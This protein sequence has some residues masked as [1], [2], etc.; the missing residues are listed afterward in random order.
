VEL[1]KLRRPL[2]HPSRRRARPKTEAPHEA[3]P[4]RLARLGTRP[5]R[6][7]TGIETG[8][9]RARGHE[10]STRSSA[11]TSMSPRRA[12]ARRSSPDHMC[13]MMFVPNSEHLIFVAPSIRRAKS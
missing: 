3:A 2:R 11:A 12:R 7:R 8:R 1:R 6:R 13:S 10:T 9:L 5:G 4:K